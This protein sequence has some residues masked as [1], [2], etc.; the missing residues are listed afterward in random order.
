MPLLLACWVMLRVRVSD[1]VPHALV[2]SLHEDHSLTV[3]FTGHGLS[4]HA[5]DSLRVVSHAAPP[6][7][8]CV[9]TVRSRDR[10][11][12]PHVR[13]H[14]PQLLHAVSVQST[15]QAWSLHAREWLT[16]VLHAAPPFWAAVTS[17]R[18]RPWVPPVPHDAV[19]ASHALHADSA[20]S[21][22]HAV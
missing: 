13:P 10:S 16:L 20:Q 14:A 1:P 21:V 2:Q 11:P 19:H 4:L 7:A 6:C 9:A 12:S 17:V 3:Q 15:G 5:S 18:V 8:A 22:T